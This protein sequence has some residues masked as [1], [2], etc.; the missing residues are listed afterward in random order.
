MDGEEGG[1]DELGGCPGACVD[2]VVGLY[3]AVDFADFEADVGPVWWCESGSSCS[4]G[5]SRGT[6]QLSWWGE[7][8]RPLCLMELGGNGG[9]VSCSRCFLRDAGPFLKARLCRAAGTDTKCGGGAE[10]HGEVHVLA[11]SGQSFAGTW[12]LDW[13]RNCYHFSLGF[14]AVYI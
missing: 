8:G 2:A 10:G 1:G 12:L 3:V 4:R 14:L 6:Y 13:Q 9:N 7:V 11:L 5:G